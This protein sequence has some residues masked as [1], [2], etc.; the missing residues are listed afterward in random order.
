MNNHPIYFFGERLHSQFLLPTKNFALHQRYVQ[1]SGITTLIQA[2]LR[3]SRKIFPHHEYPN[4]L[5]TIQL[6]LKETS[7]SNRD[8]RKK[9][10][11]D[12][13]CFRVVEYKIEDSTEKSGA[14]AEYI[15]TSKDLDS[16]KNKSISVFVPGGGGDHKTKVLLRALR[17]RMA[18]IR[19]IKSL[20]CFSQPADNRPVSHL[21]LF[22]FSS[23]RQ[24]KQVG[25][26]LASKK[27]LEHRGIA[28]ISSRS[29]A[30]DPNFD[31]S[32]DT[33][34]EFA[35]HKIYRY[36]KKDIDTHEKGANENTPS[37]WLQS[38]RYLIIRLSN[39]GVVVFDTDHFFLKKTP[40]KTF[41]GHLIFDQK[42]PVPFKE[43]G[44]GVS[45]SY[46]YLYMSIFI[47]QWIN[48]YDLTQ[49]FEKEE[50]N[51]NNNL[52]Y[53]EEFILETA[54]YANLACNYHFLRGFKE[55]KNNQN[56]IDYEISWDADWYPA[57]EL[58]YSTRAVVEKGYKFTDSDEK[59]MFD[60]LKNNQVIT[61]VPYQEIE[62][63]EIMWR[64]STLNPV[65]KTSEPYKNR[66][67][68]FD[69]ITRI[70]R[71][72][73]NEDLSVDQKMLVY[74]LTELNCDLQHIP[75][76]SNTGELEY[77]N[78][79][80]KDINP[81]SDKPKKSHGSVVRYSKLGKL[82]LADRSEIEDYLFL[83]NLLMDYDQR[84]KEQNPISIGVFGPPGSGKSFGVK[85]LVESLNN[86]GA[87]FQKNALEFNLSQMVNHN[88][89]VVA[90]H[91]I[92]N[93]CL[94]DKI[95]LIFFDEFD[96]AV[97]GTPFYW[98]KY[99]LAPMQDSCFTVDG[100]TYNLGKAVF[101]FAGGVNQ[102]FS[103][104][105]GRSRNAEF[106]QAKGPDFLSRLKGVLN[107]RGIDRQNTKEDQGMH[108]IKR[109]ILLKSCLENV[110]GEQED[111]IN[112]KL[113]YAMLKVPTFK[114]GIRSMESIIKMSHI[115]K[116]T[117]FCSSNLPPQAQ[118]DIHV[119]ARHFTNTFGN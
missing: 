116:G 40:K 71:K 5:R 3:K 49:K 115:S 84:A 73:N 23:I 13:K 70:K 9:E 111:L 109:A 32:R 63:P 44:I 94:Q 83:Q 41:C 59:N 47:Q 87:Q 62:A 45:E 26:Q 69:K 60:D 17:M 16:P 20:R 65:L 24:L 7:L 39:S 42:R 12:K 57:K 104:M 14:C 28:I 96:A 55:S 66:N 100:K 30:D 72:D 33:T 117:P 98:L 78:C 81:D 91:E 90:F 75:S 11:C 54:A 4:K 106:C 74:A 102:N 82:D 10:F 64:A 48:N 119:D 99:F 68:T 103:E 29:L 61:R 21:F 95:P 6:V 43:P 79:I 35:V 67:E 105:N 8:I 46:G 15:F 50:L 85:Q 37:H 77:Y 97:Q 80:Q 36:L 53:N 89:L 2:L 18:Y 92:R 25:K 108:I 114:H 1:D 93:A 51:K 118:L 110:V 113:A 76:L 58:E 38:F 88:E 107:I 56:K 112:P 27:N 86:S 19:K 101:I 34:Y 52:S 31:L 22:L